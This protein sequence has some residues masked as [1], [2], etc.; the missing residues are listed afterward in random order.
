MVKKFSALALAALIAWLTLAGAAATPA[1]LEA[2]IER[3][4]KELGALKAD[5]ANIKKDSGSS[6]VEALKEKSEKWDEAARVQLSGD[7]RT[8]LDYVSADTTDHFTA[9][10]VARGSVGDGAIGSATAGFVGVYNNFGAAVGGLS[11]AQ[12]G[13]FMGATLADLFQAQATGAPTGTATPDA[14]AAMGTLSN[15]AALAPMFAILPSL[16]ANGPNQTMGQI[17]AGFGGIFGGGVAGVNP[18]AVAQFMKTLS[19]ADRLAAFNALGYSAAK[20]NKDYDNDT[21]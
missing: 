15:N 16:Y 1:E 13:A 14:L 10:D 11:G 21:M 2:Q 12:Q 18:Q 20:N 4:T 9:M 19:P 8:R 6:D 17:A 3:L 7:F 5:M